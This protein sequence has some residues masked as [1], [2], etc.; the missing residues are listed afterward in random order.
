MVTWTAETKATS[1]SGETTV[2]D[3]V[4]LLAIQTRGMFSWEGSGDNPVGWEDE[5]DF[6]QAETV[7]AV[8]T[9]GFLLPYVSGTE[10]EIVVWAVETKISDTSW[11]AETKI[12]NTSWSDETKDT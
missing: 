10:G 7:Q 12:T 4:N 9:M 11:G 3:S 8:Q 2:T 5:D 6:T 1:G